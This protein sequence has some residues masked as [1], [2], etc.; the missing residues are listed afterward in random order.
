MSDGQASA[1]RA[2]VWISGQVQGVPSRALR[3]AGP[4]LAALGTPSLL[5][6]EVA[7]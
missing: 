7:A 3:P 1:K 2:H 6:E 4:R 5:Q